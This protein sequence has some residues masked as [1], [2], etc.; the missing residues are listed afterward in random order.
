MSE[1]DTFRAKINAIDDEIIKLWQARMTT[2]L[3]VARYKQARAMPVRDAGRED[4]LLE[5]ISQKAGGGL[6]IYARALYNTIMGVSRS[7]QYEYMHCA[8][9]ASAAIKTALKEAAADLP[10]CPRVACGISE[11][12]SAG[13]AADSIFAQPAIEYFSAWRD[14][15]AAVLSGRCEYG[16]LP[17]AATISG[18][19]TGIYDLIAEQGLFIM[20]AVHIKS[21]PYT[22]FVCVSDANKIYPDA[23]R[24]SLVALLPDGAGTMY[25]ALACLYTYGLKPA[26]LTL[27]SGAAGSRAYIDIEAPAGDAALHCALTQLEAEC[28]EMHYIGSYSE[29]R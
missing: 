23:N 24:T 13:M 10:P 14:V 21:E 4:A 7:Y 16:I 18:R 25:N 29:V 2:A 1:L 9:R 15:S 20:R 27:Q 19:M 6:D 17:S 26:G 5:R 22:E 11:A 12:D 28:R 8:G 3:A